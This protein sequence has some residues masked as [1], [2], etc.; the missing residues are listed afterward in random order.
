MGINAITML[1]TFILELKVAFVSIGFDDSFNKRLI[2]EYVDLAAG[3]VS[4]FNGIYMLGII[5][6]SAQAKQKL[7]NRYAHY[8]NIESLAPSADY[9]IGDTII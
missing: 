5:Y 7:P 2:E 6:Y 3:V 9:A 4:L 8:Y 1:F